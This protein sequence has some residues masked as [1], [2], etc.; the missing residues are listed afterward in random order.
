MSRRITKEEFNNRIKKRF[1]QETFTI[2]KFEGMG[3]EGIFKCDHC[4]KEIIVSKASNFLA[5]NKKYGCVNCHGLWQ[6][7]E[8]KLQKLKEKYDILST[9]VHN[10]HTYYKVKCKKCG[11]IRNTDLRNLT[12]HSCGCESG[13]YRNRTGEE[14][15]KQVNNLHPYD[16]YQLVSEYKNQT[17][18]VK[19]LHNKC[20][21]I[22]EVR[23]NDV[24]HG[25]QCPKCSRKQSKG[26]Q[27]IEYLLKK[28]SYT[29][30]PE[31]YLKDSK[32]R[33]DF[34]LPDYNIAIE[35]NGKQHYEEVNF[36][37]GSLKCYQERDKKKRKYCQEN[38]IQLIEIPYY[39]TKEEIK[40][41]IKNL[42]S[43]TIPEG[44]KN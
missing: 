17:T 22:W 13:V 42:G 24:M 4:G 21:F 35:Y 23:P 9:S 20:G 7:R 2:I 12:E 26:E 1:P 32:Q 16:T 19:L 40:D 18:K 30:E 44:S 10:T 36:F 8:K 3:V 28:Y 25:A 31:K 43:T 29:Y 15:I 34:Y 39:K 6:Q 37:Q 41:I 33:F 14:F 27:F 5:P 11:H 38:N